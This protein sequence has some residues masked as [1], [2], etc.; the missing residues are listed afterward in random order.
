MKRVFEHTTFNNIE[1]KITAHILYK[2]WEYLKK[3]VLSKEL[4]S[5]EECNK[6][7]IEF[8]IN[9]EGLF[10]SNCLK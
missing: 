2:Y 1:N 10:Y 5:E 6:F 8:M 4:I 9:N 3:E 7:F